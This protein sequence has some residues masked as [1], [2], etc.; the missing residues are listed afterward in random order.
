MLAH[1]ITW[2]FVMIG[3]VALEASTMTLTCIWFAVGA[4]C[5]FVVSFFH[6]AFLTQ[7]FVF[8]IVS[9][10]ALVLVKPVVKEKMLTR[11]TATNAD[12]IL[13]QTAVVTEDIDNDLAQGKVTVKGQVWTA[14]S[15]DDGTAIPKGSRVKVKEISGV[16]LIVEKTEE[17]KECTL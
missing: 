10:V 8:A 15:A 6:T 12:R 13:G 11:R 2:L 17:T 7:L 16:K 1:Y 9:G 5:A 3:L 14:R 4:F